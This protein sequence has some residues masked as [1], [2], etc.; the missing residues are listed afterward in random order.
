MKNSKC[1][2]RDILLRGGLAIDEGGP[3]TTR[4]KRL[5]VR[6][7]VTSRAGPACLRL[8]GLTVAL[9]KTSK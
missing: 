2:R 3:V 5:H 9:D 7:S 6:P 8:Q 4:M 1:G